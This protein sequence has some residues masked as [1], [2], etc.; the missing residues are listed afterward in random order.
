[1]ITP[2]EFMPWLSIMLTL[3]IATGSVFY[4]RGSL[5]KTAGE[6]QE[7]VINALNSEISALNT[8]IDTLDREN[9]Y[10]HDVQE[11]IVE[12]LKKRGLIITIER[13]SVTIEDVASRTQTMSRL[14]GEK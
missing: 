8:R 7:R 3:V 9:K 14:T 6:V 11:L 13:N 5:S 1:M 10:F 2:A 12:S 4:F